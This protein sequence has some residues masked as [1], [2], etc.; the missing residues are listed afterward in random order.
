MAIEGSL[1]FRSF[2]GRWLRS[3]FGLRSGGGRSSVWRS[4]AAMEVW[5]SRGSEELGS[6]FPRPV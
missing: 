1:G 6:V 2:R 5:A 4:G 3:Q